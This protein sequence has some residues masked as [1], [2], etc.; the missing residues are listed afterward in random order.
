[1]RLVVFD[2]DGTITHRD[3]L[4]PYIMGFL[5]RRR[6]SHL[7]LLKV[8]PAVAAFLLGRAD[9]GQLKAALM[10]ATLGGATRG[11]IEEWNR[12]FIPWVITHGSR[13]GAL[14]AIQEHQR[15]GDVLVLMSASP[16]LYVPDLGRALGF[17]ATVCTG[18]SWGADGRLEGSL[19]T[20]N[21][22]GQ[23]K[24]LCLTALKAQ[25]PGLPTIAYGNAASDLPHLLLSDEPRLVNAS[26]RARRSAAHLG[27]RPY[28]LWR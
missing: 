17:A 23:E 8:I 9:R 10:R 11:E 25:Y 1:M 5:R 27:V 14:E 21:R 15:R 22:R 13:A 19:A 18:V 26:A 4:W 2:L 28:A 16:D 12:Q 6:R 24:A 20:P 3:T 7:R